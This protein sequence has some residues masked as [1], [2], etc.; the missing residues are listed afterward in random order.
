M[1]LYCPAAATR[2]REK[3]LVNIKELFHQSKLARSD[4]ALRRLLFPAVEVRFR[5]LGCALGAA[6]GPKLQTAEAHTTGI[7]R[8]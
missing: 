3:K 7:A 8:E 6:F 4:S 2:S 1:E 5:S